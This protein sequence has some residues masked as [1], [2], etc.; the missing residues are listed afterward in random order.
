MKTGQYLTDNQHT[1]W[2]Q[3]VSEMSEPMPCA[4]TVEIGEKALPNPV[5]GFGAAITASSCY[6]MS[7][8]GDE[9]RAGFIHEI[10]DPG[11]LHLNTARLTIGSSDY[12]PEIYTYDDVPFDEELKHFSITRDRSFVLPMQKEI[13]AFAKDLFLFASPWSPPGWMKT[14]GA[15][16]GG[17]MRSRYLD[18]YAEYF[19]RYLKA[20]QA[21]G[22]NIHAVS[23]QNEP[24]TDTAGHYPGC[25]WHPEIEAD[26]IHR[27]RSALD[28]NGLDTQIWMFDHNYDGWRR[29]QWMLEEDPRL[30]KDIDAVAFHY[31]QECP[32]FLDALV[33]EFPGLP[34][35]FTEGGPRV[36]DHYSED[37]CKWGRIMARVFNHG[38]RSFIGWNLLLDE[39][40]GPHV[41]PFFCGGL[42]TR[43]SQT[44]ELTRSGQYRA[45]A[46]FSHFVRRG[47][48]VLP[49]RTKNDGLRF[50]AYPDTGEP[51]DCCAFRNPDD[52]VVLVLVNPSEK[53]RKQVQCRIHGKWH[54]IPLL[55]NSVSTTVFD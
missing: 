15:I 23:P 50:F 54:L 8:M 38:C 7:L 42:V 5:I 22:L 48:E 44:G 16:A 2:E 53:D 30:L 25:I 28:R 40:G 21:E 55:P 49:C 13:A 51:V 6:N 43:N 17:Y 34:L 12:S 52:S 4:V 35:Q 26:F 37:Y 32:E 11:C 19:I 47:A 46:H 3:P 41:G 36:N 31:Y 39:T 20:M 29:V 1:L 33:E 27:L 9:E 24:N 10:Y 18:V 14:G 45:M